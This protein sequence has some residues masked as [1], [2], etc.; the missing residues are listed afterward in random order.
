MYKTSSKNTHDSLLKPEFET[1]T[2]SYIVNFE[3]LKIRSW[4]KIHLK[5]LHLNRTWHDCWLVCWAI[6]QVSSFSPHHLHFIATIWQYYCSSWQSQ[7]CQKVLKK[8]TCCIWRAELMMK[9]EYLRIL[10]FYV[11]RVGEN[12][13]NVV[14]LYCEIFCSFTAAWIGLI[15]S[16]IGDILLLLN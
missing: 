1:Q 16:Y 8:Y 2:I 4:F 11:D 3:H 10:L 7:K 9:Y 14:L 12:V 13:Q 5:Q 15:Y 6:D